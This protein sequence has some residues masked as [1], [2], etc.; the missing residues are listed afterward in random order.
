[1]GVSSIPLQCTIIA[2]NWLM[3]FHAETCKQ[4]G[5]PRNC[6]GTCATGGNPALDSLIRGKRIDGT[7]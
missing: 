3:G 7:A 2:S 1:M 6:E 5:D 4:V